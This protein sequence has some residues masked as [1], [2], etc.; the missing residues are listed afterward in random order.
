MIRYSALTKNIAV[1]VTPVYLD[2]E[3]SYLEHRF[4]F[5][6]FISIR[7]KG[8][9]PVRLRRRFWMIEEENGEYSEVDGEGVVGKQPLI[10]PGKSHHYNSFCILATP[11]GAMEGY[12]TM[13]DI[14]GDQFRAFIPRFDL[15]AMAN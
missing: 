8:Q 7:N 2:G 1:T 13:E 6:Y 4:V 5:A 11:E 10:H 3:S 9:K 14:H 12:Y 15:R